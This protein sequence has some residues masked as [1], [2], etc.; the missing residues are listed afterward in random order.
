[1][2]NHRI[3]LTGA[4]TACALFGTVAAHGGLC[5]DEVVL[6]DIEE[7]VDEVPTRF[8]GNWNVA[9]SDGTMS[10]SVSRYGKVAIAGNLRNGRPFNTTAQ[11]SFWNKDLYAMVLWV[12]KGDSLAFSIT[13]PLTQ[14]ENALPVISGLGSAVVGRHDSL[15]GDRTYQM[16]GV[17]M[18][19]L[20]VESL[21]QKM[22]YYGKVFLEYMPTN[23]PLKITGRK[24][25]FP[26][27]GKVVYVRGTVDVDSSKVG[28]NASGLKLTYN[29]G[30]GTFKGSFKSYYDTDKKKIKSTAVNVAG[31]VIG[32]VGYGFA[33][34]RDVGGV[35]VTIKQ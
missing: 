2:I 35:P 18:T 21:S 16:D 11:L 1:M 30:S 19:N 31:V 3:W 15:S 5:S 12:S 7:V 25:V 10:F 26:K 17:S 6:C 14:G 9:W 28:D 29:A 8:R 22:P 32:D 4:F 27:A 13:M 33:F 34:I 24:W 20:V 23:M